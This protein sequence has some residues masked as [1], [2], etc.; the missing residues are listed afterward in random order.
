MAIEPITSQATLLNSLQDMKAE[1]I[2]PASNLAVDNLR[3]DRV[4]FTEVMS[5]AL[6]AIDQQQHKA[7]AM[8]TAVET[9]QSDDLVGAMVAFGQAEGFFTQLVAFLGVILAAGNAAGGY[10]VTE[11][12]L[13]MFKS[14]KGEK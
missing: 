13:D 4:N 9:G 5:S 2:A 7:A 11:R 6:N 10:V 1:V 14:S 12:M 8:Q 3:A